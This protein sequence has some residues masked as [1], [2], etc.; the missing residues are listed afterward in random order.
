MKDYKEVA[1]S[2]FQRSEEILEKKRKRRQSGRKAGAM[3]LCLCLVFVLGLGIWQA[4]RPASAASPEQL[5]Y[6]GDSGSGSGLDGS[7]DGYSIPTGEPVPGSGEVSEQDAAA[8]PGYNGSF[9]AYSGALDGEST[10]PPERITMISSY[11]E[12]DAA[13]CYAVPENG[14]VCCSLPLAGAMEEYGSEVL[15][16]V[17]VDVFQDGQPLDAGGA[18]VK[19]EADRLADLGYTTVSE[20]FYSGGVAES[21]TFSLHATLE[22]LTGFAANGAYGYMLFLYDER[23]G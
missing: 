13:A 23:V 9:P 7:P 10:A 2:V 21:F 18:A 20:T 17:V 6:T 4:A 8:S 15:Y 12:A 5:A 3:A 19:A 22:Q 11:G 14:S 16:Q 1:D